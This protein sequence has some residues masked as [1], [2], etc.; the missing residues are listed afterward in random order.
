METTT[1]TQKTSSNRDM[2]VGVAG[3]GYWGPNHVRNMVGLEGI[4]VAMK[5]VA[6]PDPVRRMR[7]ATMFPSVG[8]VESVNAMIEDDEIDAIVI[9]TPVHTHYELVK[10]A[11]LAGKHVLVEKPMTTSV[12]KARELTALA[13]E[14]GLTLMVGHTFEYTPSV[15]YI[16]DFIEQGGLGDVLNIRSQRVNLGQHRSNVNVMWDLA[17]HDISIILYLLNR[18]PTHATALGR[19]HING[20]VD[21]IVS[22][23]L[24]FEDNFMANIVLSWLDPRKVR[25]MTIIGSDKMLVYDDTHTIE[26]IRIYDKGVDVPAEY[27]SFGEFQVS[28]RNGDIISPQIENFE[29]LT[30]QSSHFVECIRTGKTPR[31]DGASGTRVVQVLAAGQLSLNRGGART[32]LD[33][34]EVMTLDGTLRR[35]PADMEDRA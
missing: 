16:H 9:S 20:Y 34:P 28:Y 24:E 31:S 7:A 11:L 26:K 5:T 33:D 17:P 25:E 27:R 6:D 19:A 8:T 12:D 15:G 18:M 35:R 30:V 21:D 29:P 4:G 13:E 22:L 14:R 23:N 2:T 3:F 1:D 32:A 10:D